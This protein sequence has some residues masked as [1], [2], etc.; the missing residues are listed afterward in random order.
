M[1]GEMQ[2]VFLGCFKSAIRYSSP[3]PG[4]DQDADGNV[5]F[6]TRVYFRQQNG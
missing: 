3:E 6:I 5:R 2:D 1:F 4:R